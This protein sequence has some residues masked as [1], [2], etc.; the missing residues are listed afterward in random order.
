MV[1]SLLIMGGGLWAFL[2]F[3]RSRRGRSLLGALGA[4]DAGGG[5]DEIEVCTRHQLS[6]SSSLAVVR[7][8]GRTLLVGVTETG[9]SVLAEGDDL[10]EP[11]EPSL[12]VEAVNDREPAGT[13]VRGAAVPGPS[14]MGVVDALRELTVRR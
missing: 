14:R 3:A 12:E 1:V 13:R 7:V 5:T 6:R 10:R 9:I 8:G 11:A 4:R 2:R